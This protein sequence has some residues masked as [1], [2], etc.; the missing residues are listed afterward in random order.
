MIDL[1]IHKKLDGATGPMELKIDLTVPNQALVGVYGVSGAGKTT[2][3]RIMAGLTR[4]DKAEITVN[5]T[6]WDHS[7][8]GIYLQPG[9]RKAGFVFQ[10][11]ALFPNMS[12]EA[13]LK[14]AMRKGS[15]N[16]KTAELIAMMELTDLRHKKPDQLSGGQQQRVAVARALASEPDV[17]LLDE[18]LSALDTAMRHKLQDH[19]LEAHRKYNLHTFLVSHD[20]SEIM[21]MCS[22]VVVMDKGCISRQGTPQDVFG[23]AEISGKFKFT[24]DVVNME[25]QGFLC[26]VSVMIGN[27][28]VKVV[29]DASEVNALKAGDK[30]MVSSKAFNPVIRKLF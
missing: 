24:G 8:K 3:L 15:D 16:G 23:Q 19:I 28:V 9:K 26:I 14:Y 29:A 2:L 18:P 7:A 22:Y 27:E 20:I 30:V 11:Y 5:G 1:Q 21:R 12:V 13:N 6:A 17:L 25:L 10:D 4:A